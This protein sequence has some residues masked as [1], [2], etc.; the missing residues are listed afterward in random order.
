MKYVLI[1]EFDVEIYR[2]SPTVRIYLNNIMLTDI[3]LD[4]HTQGTVIF[5]YKPS[6]LNELT[7][8]FVNGD[9]NYT[10]GF[11]TKSTCV[12]PIKLFILPYAVA[13]NID[14][15]N[16]KHAI[17]FGKK[18]FGIY[19]HTGKK[20]KE[21]KNILKGYQYI[22]H[23]YKARTFW[24]EQ[25][26]HIYYDLFPITNIGETKKFKIQLYKKHDHLVKKKVIGYWHHD[27]G[28]IEYIKQGLTWCDK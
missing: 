10:N 20:W 26:A 28:A 8:E 14:K 27:Y 19:R 25:L 11:M 16:Q 9:S 23:W 15:I 4:V 17:F 21:N 24:P 3:S 13:K 2:R 18:N 12:K 7:V 1:Y 5:D 6:Y 22:K